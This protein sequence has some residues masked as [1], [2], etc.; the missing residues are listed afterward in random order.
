MAEALGRY[1]ATFVVCKAGIIGT[2]K[3]V[4][5]AVHHNVFRFQRVTC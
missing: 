4:E 2:G 3:T 1:G 5:V